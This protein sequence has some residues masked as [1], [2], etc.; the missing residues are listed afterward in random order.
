[1]GY[2]SPEHN[3]H[4]REMAGHDLRSNGG[5]NSDD[6]GVEQLDGAAA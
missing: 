5:S 1:M 3:K 6:D 2:K 4:I